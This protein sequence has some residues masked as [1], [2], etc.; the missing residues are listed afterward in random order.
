MTQHTLA[1]VLVVCVILGGIYKVDNYMLKLKEEARKDAAN[2]PSQQ[3]S[4]GTSDP[5]LARATADSAVNAGGTEGGDTASV[6]A[7]EAAAH[8]KADNIIVAALNEAIADG[9]PPTDAEIEAAT[10]NVQALTQVV[11]ECMRKHLPDK[12]DAVCDN[13]IQAV[14]DASAQLGKLKSK[15]GRAR[16]AASEQKQVNVRVLDDS[17]HANQATSTPDDADGFRA[18]TLH[19][20]FP[21]IDTL[22][23][24][25][26]LNSHVDPNVPVDMLNYA[27]VDSIPADC[28]A[29]TTCTGAG[30]RGCKGIR[31][32]AKLLGRG[33]ASIAKALSGMR[34]SNGYELA[35]EFAPTHLTAIHLNDQGIGVLGARMISDVVGRLNTVTSLQL[36]GNDLS[37]RGAEAV[38]E[39]AVSGGTYGANRQFQRAATSTALETLSLEY[40]DIRTLGATALAKA[41]AAEPSPS[42]KALFLGANALGADG[43]VAIAEGLAKNTNLI[44]LDV[45]TNV[46]RDRGAAA[47][48]TLLEANTPL[49]IIELGDNEFG[50]PGAKQ[51][52]ASLGSNSNLRVLN[53]DDNK[54]ADDGCVAIA[55]ALA[56][57]ANATNVSKLGLGNN[58]I[59]A[60]GA[61]ALIEML[62][63]NTK[64]VA[65]DVGDNSISDAD[66]ESIRL[67]VA[68]NANQA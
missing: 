40:N 68:R 18:C 6:P 38:A 45:G 30:E 19:D 31:K 24:E 49:Q 8:Q 48:A 58:K 10:A 61:A 15:A 46:I 63:V 41:L 27:I 1:L 56:E 51:I 52:A 54:I 60:K 28:N 42:L 13:A 14:T 67:G 32:T 57:H 55:N 16:A 47:F 21:R 33:A 50:N 44:E 22:Q 53:L 25:N 59:R 7:A 11:K 35:P 3:P 9:G 17:A 2:A 5:T 66:V 34:N 62:K 29:I 37:D 23:D 64:I 12:D 36:W 26:V 43:A 65:L 39:L 20:I 4:S